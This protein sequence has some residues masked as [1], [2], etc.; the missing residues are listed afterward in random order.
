MRLVTV[1]AAAV[2]ATS[3]AACSHGAAATASGARSGPKSSTLR[4]GELALQAP[5]V[6]VGMLAIHPL[7]WK[8]GMGSLIG[9]HAEHFARGQYCRFRLHLL[10]DDAT[11][12]DYESAWL[13]LGWT[14]GSTTPDA[15]A[16]KI[17]RQPQEM[18]VGAHDTV[19][20]DVW[21][22]YP[23]GAVPK[24]LT[25]RGTVVNLPGHTWPAPVKL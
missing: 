18:Q 12:V 9:T 1:A 10:A 3:V 23:I 5:T 16:M 14:T 13:R 17:A 15:E 20:L 19:E 8:C 7:S 21:F 2:I 4:L 24:T 6:R 11:Y 22:D 25:I